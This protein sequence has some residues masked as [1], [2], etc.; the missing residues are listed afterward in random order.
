MDEQS[1]FIEALERHD[2]AERAAFLDRTEVPAPARRFPEAARRTGSRKAK[3][4]VVASFSAH[5][6]YA[7]RNEVPPCRR[8]PWDSL[9]FR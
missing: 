9:F 7:Q 8:P 5:E 2:P 6:Q 1:L 3:G 4:R